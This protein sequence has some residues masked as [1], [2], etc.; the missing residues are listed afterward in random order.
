M[1]KKTVAGA[2]M[3]EFGWAIFGWNWDGG[4]NGMKARSRN[5]MENGNRN[6]IGKWQ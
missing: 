3:T 2:E 5:V 1:L 6:V 4:R